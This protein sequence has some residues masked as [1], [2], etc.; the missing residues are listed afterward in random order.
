MKFF[1]DTAVVDEIKE[2]AD[3][4]LVDGITTNPSL[5]K[6]SGRDIRDVLTQICEIISG[7]VSAEVVA[8]DYGSMIN[9]AEKLKTIAENIVIKLPMT[10]D[11]LKACKTLSEQNV[12]TNVTLCFSAAQALLAAK[13]RATYVSPFIGRLDD[14]GQE[15]MQLINEII[16]IYKAQNFRTKVLVASIRSPIH[17]VHSARLGADVVT[18][19]PSIMKQ[20]IKHP[21][22]DSGIE[23]FLS[24]WR[25]TGQKI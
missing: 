11:G 13:V 23:T 20:L 5:I 12:S 7:P 16:E 8:T 22:T 21:L 6:K 15:G 18:I 3:Y 17:V 9:E 14:I 2:L 19:S 1:L 4:G 25:D 10:M 24:D